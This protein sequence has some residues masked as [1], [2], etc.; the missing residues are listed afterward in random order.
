MFDLDERVAPSGEAW[1]TYLPDGMLGDILSVADGGSSWDRLERIGGWERLIAW[2]QAAQVREIAGFAAAALTDPVYGGD[3]EQV[4]SSVV[5]E[6][7]LMTRLA[8]RTAAGRVA[9]A[10]ALVERLPETLRALSEGRISLPAARAIVEETASLGREH[11]EA[12]QARVLARAGDQTPS[13]IRAATRRAVARADADAVRRRA[14][15][16][17]QERHVRLI[18]EPDGMATL[19][20]YL[21]APSAVAVYGVLD[22]CARRAGGPD[23]ARSM[24]ARRA[25]ALVDLI[26]DRLA[27]P[28]ASAP[29]GRSGAT[30]SVAVSGAGRSG[31]GDSG[32]GDLAAR[33]S[34]LGGSAAGGSAGH[35]SDGRVRRDRVQVQIRVTVP[36]T[37]LLG[38]DQSP[39]ELAG[40]GPISADAARELAAHG[41]WRRLVTDPL[42]GAL[43]DHGTTRYRPPPSLA[44][45]VIARDQT[46]DFPS[47]RIPAHRCDLDHRVPYGPDVGAGPTSADNL[48]PRCRPHHRLKA[49][50]GWRLTREPGGAIAWHT[51]AGHTYLRQPGPIGEID[52]DRVGGELI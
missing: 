33:D 8:P 13:Q 19:S 16:V 6:V 1:S 37:T 34:G 27:R 22:E 32:T 9:D 42:S 26:L 18:P 5:A 12:V 21:P 25:D 11:L 28:A 24:D 48:G 23:E 50:P 20:A 41:T 10:T 36:L 31:D 40:Y 15:Q 47:C 4:E 43:L 35:A 14:E 2:A 44:E 17:R 30:D 3:T 38:L 7:G 29:A 39:G 49:S 52:R 51:P 46:C 45:H